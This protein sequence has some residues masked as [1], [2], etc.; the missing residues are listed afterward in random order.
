MSERITI[1]VFLENSGLSN[2]LVLFPMTYITRETKEAS[3]LLLILNAMQSLPAFM[4]GVRTEDCI[5]RQ[6]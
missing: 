6:I 1:F 5:T 4:L 3:V 2:E